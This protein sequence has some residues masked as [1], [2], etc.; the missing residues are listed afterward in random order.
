[1]KKRESQLLKL[2]KQGFTLESPEGYRITGDPSTNYLELAN[3][4]GSEGLE[5]LNAEGLKNALGSY[6]RY[7]SQLKEDTRF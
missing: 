2:L 4:F 7:L 3:P 1:M 6:K 5:I